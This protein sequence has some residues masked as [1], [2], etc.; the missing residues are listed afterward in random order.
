MKF[1]ALFVFGQSLAAWEERDSSATARGP[2]GASDADRTH[3]YKPDNGYLWDWLSSVYA[4]S[5]GGSYSNIYMYRKSGMAG[6]DANCKLLSLKSPIDSNCFYQPLMLQNW[7]TI[8]NCM[9]GC[10]ESPML[11]SLV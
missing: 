3:M 9:L 4:S 8:T 1:L 2:Q 11:R 6:L 7:P 5:A 10:I